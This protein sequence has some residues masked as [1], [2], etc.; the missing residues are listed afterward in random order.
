MC[1]L[2]ELLSWCLEGN[3]LVGYDIRP[4][5]HS[6]GYVHDKVEDLKDFY[7]DNKGDAIGV[8]TLAHLL[9]KGKEI[10]KG[11]HSAITDAR[12]HLALYK[13]K[14]KDKY[15]SRRVFGLEVQRPKEIFAKGDYCT[16][17]K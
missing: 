4:D 3:T 14:Q 17:K 9:L 13:E 1:T 11:Y 15:K 10:Q 6:M 7:K 2:Y 16:C 5:L 12:I 8:K